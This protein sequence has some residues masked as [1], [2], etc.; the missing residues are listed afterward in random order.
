MRRDSISNWVSELLTT[1][2]RACARRL[3]DRKAISENVAGAREPNV[4][5]YFIFRFENGHGNKSF[6]SIYAKNTAETSQQQAKLTD[7]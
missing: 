2:E 1:E 7:D 4:H 3:R 6:C 5:V